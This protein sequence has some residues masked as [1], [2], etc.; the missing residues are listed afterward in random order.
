[1]DAIRRAGDQ[2]ALK[3]DLRS[4]WWST[5]LYLIAAL[6]ER[7][8]NVRRILIVKSGSPAVLGVA[9][10]PGGVVMSSG[11]GSGIGGPPPAPVAAP[12]G[13]ALGSDHEEFV[14]M[15]S[16]SSILAT[17]RQRIPAVEPFEEHLRDRP[18]AFSALEAE[19]SELVQEW[20]RA[21][22]EGPAPTAGASRAKEVSLKV[23]LSADLLRRWFADAMLREPIR[24]SDLQRASVVDLL[25]LLDYPSDFVPVVTRKRLEGNSAERVDVL[26]KATL[27]ARLARSYLV[28]LMDR[29]RIS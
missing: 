20:R 9:P 12:G 3:I 6:A 5:R 10:A 8:T 21:F 27:N 26:D 13:M 19:I 7:L 1:V 17:L 18:T 24:I 4:T 11:I 29:A 16:T 15:I 14:G 28:E 23:D 25:R 2:R 22:G